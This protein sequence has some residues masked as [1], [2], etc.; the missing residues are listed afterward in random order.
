MNPSSIRTYDDSR[1]KMNTIGFTAMHV[2]CGPSV[3]LTANRARWKCKKHQSD[4]ELRCVC[5]LHSFTVCISNLHLS[6][7]FTRLCEC[8]HRLQ[9]VVISYKLHN[10]LVFVSFAF[11]RKRFYSLCVSCKSLIQFD[12]LLAVDSC[13][14]N[15]CWRSGISFGSNWPLCTVK[16]TT[17]TSTSTVRYY[18]V[19]LSAHGVNLIA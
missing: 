1:T 5:I 16:P 11:R 18:C 4:D 13:R 14:R 10:F 3:K 12:L 6:D 15:V 2:Q 17:S 8:V 19:S 9:T 7:K